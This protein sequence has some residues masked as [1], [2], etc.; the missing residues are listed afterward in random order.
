MSILSVLWIVW[1]VLAT[2]LLAMLAYRGNLTRYEEDCLFLGDCNNNEKT[3]Q[4]RILAKV[5]KI[6]PALRIMAGATCAM[7][8]ALIGMYVWE[9]I[10]QFNLTT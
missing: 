8:A 10:R 5:R 9:A 4:E 3:E 1:A 7:S 2:V 6:Q